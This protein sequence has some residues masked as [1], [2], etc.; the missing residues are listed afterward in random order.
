[1]MFDEMEEGVPLDD[2]HGAMIPVSEQS[3][4]IF[5]ISILGGVP[6]LNFSQIFHEKDCIVIVF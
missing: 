4:F 5:L 6:L 1:M 3:F 2:V